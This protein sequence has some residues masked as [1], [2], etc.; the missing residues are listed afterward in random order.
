MPQ[1]TRTAQAEDD[2]VEI[3]DA[4]ARRSMKAA[5]R[6]R[7]EIEATITRLANSP[8][9][10]RERPDLAPEL[11]SYPV[12]RHIIF[13]YITVEGIEIAR[14]IFGARDT[15]PEMFDG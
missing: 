5:E 14:V 6:L 4:V 10:G 9:L 15:G 7:A 2:L 11:R 1:V 3:F 13:Y 8:R 12:G